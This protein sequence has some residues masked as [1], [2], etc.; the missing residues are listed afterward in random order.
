[1]IVLTGVGKSGDVAR[2]GAS[3]FQSVHLPAQFIHATDLLHGGL[4]VIESSPSSVL[5]CISHSGATAE[6]QQLR[7][8]IPVGTCPILITGNDQIG[9]PTDG[10][11]LS[12][13]IDRDGSRH[14]TIPVY[15]SIAQL[16]ILGDI[17]CT[18]ADTMTVEELLV[19]HPHGALSAAYRKEL[20][21]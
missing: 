19:G 21:S 1:M 16:E 12:Y 18:V 13:R 7:V 8:H 3:L 9:W 4:G 6:V 10:I 15:S 11:V 2:L 14:G 5:I 17:A 20:Q